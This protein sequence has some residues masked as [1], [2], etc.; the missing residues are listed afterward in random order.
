MQATTTGNVLKGVLPDSQRKRERGTYGSKGARTCAVVSYMGE[1]EG[2]LASDGNKG[3][4]FP[5][6]N[7]PTTRIFRNVKARLNTALKQAE[8]MSFLIPVGLSWSMCRN[9][10]IHT[11]RVVGRLSAK[12]THL[13]FALANS[14]CVACSGDRH[15]SVGSGPKIRHA[16][17]TEVGKNSSWCTARIPPLAGRASRA[18]PLWSGRSSWNCTA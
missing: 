9:V 2:I 12:Q 3:R 16:V 13:A 1:W 6:S 5:E 18:R 11:L 17:C 15:N 4:I 8:K 14:L 7:S 10:C